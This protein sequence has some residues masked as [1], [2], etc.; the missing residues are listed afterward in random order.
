MALGFFLERYY[1]KPLFDIFVDSWAAY[2][3]KHDF[4]YFPSK[5]P[6][7]LENQKN[8]ATTG[9][10][11]RRQKLICGQ[12]HDRNCYFMGGLA[13]HAGLFSTLDTVKSMGQF[14]L[15]AIKDPQ[16][17]LD[18]YLSSYAKAGLGFDKP[19]IRGTNRHLSLTA[20]GHFG[21]TGT[22]VWIDPQACQKEGIIIAL[23]TNRVNCSEKPEGIFDLRLKINQ[24]IYKNN[25]LL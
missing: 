2:N 10:C 16:S 8:I 23:L 17:E 25:L 4:K 5:P 22:S 15:K 19:S 12:V 14:F 3:I 6:S 7:Y 9:F 18:Y 11:Y 1:K 20:F 13:G 24:A 21:F